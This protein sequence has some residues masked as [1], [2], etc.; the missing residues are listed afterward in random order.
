MDA[1]WNIFNWKLPLGFVFRYYSDDNR[2]YDTD[3]HI[4]NHESS[5]KSEMKFNLGSDIQV[6]LKIKALNFI[7]RELENDN[8]GDFEVNFD[9]NEGD[10]EINFDDN[11]ST[12]II[13]PL[14]AIL[15]I[16]GTNRTIIHSKKKKGKIEIIMILIYLF[17]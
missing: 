12:Y 2:G 3:W 17:R 16:D 5:N 9:D 15:I 10:S 8:E 14:I 6:A 7:S 13:I 11:I 4:F 1:T